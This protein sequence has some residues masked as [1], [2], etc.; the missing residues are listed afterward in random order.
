MVL[1]LYGEGDCDCGECRVMVGTEKVTKG[2][3]KVAK[4]GWFGDQLFPENLENYL[5]F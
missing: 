1:E 4:G 3:K 5:A 2:G